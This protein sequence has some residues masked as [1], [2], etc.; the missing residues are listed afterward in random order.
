[1]KN[2]FEKAC[3]ECNG[4]KETIETAIQTSSSMREDIKS[5]MNSVILEV[6]DRDFRCVM[7]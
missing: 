7:D 2:E 3:E 5:S 6:E 1:M 4:E